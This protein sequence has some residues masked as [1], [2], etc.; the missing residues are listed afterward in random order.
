MTV[1]CLGAA[2]LHYH[3]MRADRTPHDVDDAGFAWAD[4]E[5]PWPVPAGG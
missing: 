2:Q 4:I 3:P 5:C 1:L